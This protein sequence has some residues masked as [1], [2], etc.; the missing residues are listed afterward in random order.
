MAHTAKWVGP[1]V[2]V[3]GSA[4][5]EAQY[6]GYELELDGLPA[7]SVPVAWDTDN[8]YEFDLRVLGLPYGQ[9]TLRIRVVNHLGNRSDYSNAAA[10]EFEDER[11]PDS[12]KS[13]AVV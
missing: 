4:F 13:L 10:F 1:T 12:P 2:N 8:N 7:V 9:H 6:R 5:D 3:D 11:V